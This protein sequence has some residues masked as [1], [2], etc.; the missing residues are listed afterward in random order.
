M[1]RYFVN[2]MNHQSVVGMRQNADRL[3]LPY[4]FL[5]AV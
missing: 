2:D 3:A 1:L 4:T 5:D